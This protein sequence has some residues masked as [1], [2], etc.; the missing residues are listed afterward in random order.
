[1]CPANREGALR[2][3]L[4]SCDR[5]TLRDETR[6]FNSVV[7]VSG[8]MVCHFKDDLGPYISLKLH[9][10]NVQKVANEQGRL[11]TLLP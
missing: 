6:S 9:T 1:M 7:M 2:I 8:K 11:I 4:V 5:L 10:K 3:D